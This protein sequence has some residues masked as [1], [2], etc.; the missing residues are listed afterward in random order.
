M[1]DFFF[2]FHLAEC[3]L[4]TTS[5]E[6]DQVAAAACRGLRG[7]ENVTTKASKLVSN[8]STPIPHRPLLRSSS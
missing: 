7:E 5:V 4:P 2:F 8:L 1:P 3:T 6:F